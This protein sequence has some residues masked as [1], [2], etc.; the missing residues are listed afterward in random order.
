MATKNVY[1]KDGD[2]NAWV[3]KKIE[4]GRFRSYSHAVEMALKLLKEKEEAKPHGAF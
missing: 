1:I 4:G 3:E 2:L